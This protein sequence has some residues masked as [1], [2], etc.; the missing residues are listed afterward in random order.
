MYQ[1]VKHLQEQLKKLT[2]KTSGKHEEKENQQN[3]NTH[4]NLMDQTSPLIVNGEKSQ[5]VSDERKMSPEMRGGEGGKKQ[6]EAV[7][8]MSELAARNPLYTSLHRWEMWES[9]NQSVFPSLGRTPPPPACT[10]HP[11]PQTKETIHFFFYRS[12]TIPPFTS[13][14][15]S[16]HI[17][18]FSEM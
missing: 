7:K 11:S 2:S 17:S 18:L 15:E 4:Q 14:G 12:G 5:H 8:K 16:I 6:A 3:G 10:Y 13:W 1:L 9:E